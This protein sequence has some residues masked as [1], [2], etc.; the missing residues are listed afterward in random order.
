MRPTNAAGLAVLANNRLDD[1]Y[2]VDRAVNRELPRTD[3]GE[4]TT[5]PPEWQE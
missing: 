4:S 2:A 5:A 1:F 3:C